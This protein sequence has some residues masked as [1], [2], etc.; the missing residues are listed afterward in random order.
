MLIRAVQIGRYLYH[1]LILLILQFQTLR[2]LVLSQRGSFL[3]FKDVNF[4]DILFFWG[5]KTFTLLTQFH[6]G[7]FQIIAEL[8]IL[9]KCQLQRRTSESIPVAG[10]HELGCRGFY[11][12]KDNFI[13][14][15]RKKYCINICFLLFI[16]TRLDYF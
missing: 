11:L 8:R 14:R 10:G 15:G 4:H 1:S 13:L 16:I 12:C 6:E 9:K 7:F 2:Q 3:F 5:A